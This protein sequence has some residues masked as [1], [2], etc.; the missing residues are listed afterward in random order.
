MLVEALGSPSHVTKTWEM[1]R[2]APAN[3]SLDSLGKTRQQASCGV[4]KL[5]IRTVGQVAC[6]NEKWVPVN[7]SK[8]EEGVPKGR[9]GEFE[10]TELPEGCT[11]ADLKTRIVQRLNLSLRKH[12]TLRWWGQVLEPDSATLV[13]LNL[14][15]GG[16]LDLSL[17]NRTMAEI[18]ELKGVEL[19]T[20]RVR[21]S[22]GACVTIQEVGPSTQV[23]AIK[24]TIVKG[25][26]FGPLIDP[27]AP[28]P[29]ELFY[30]PCFNAD[31]VFGNAMGDETTLGSHKVIHGDVMFLKLPPPPKEDTGGKDAKGKKK[32]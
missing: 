32:K 31:S 18:E 26:L 25:K 19:E 3:F 20:V 7:P 4:S 14:R 12:L 1:Q 17:R 13:A 21:V 8:S 22:E 9:N 2:Q 24:E 16:A 10:L 23:K 15:D 29:L 28:P 27:K 30:S 11:L 6:P 5:V